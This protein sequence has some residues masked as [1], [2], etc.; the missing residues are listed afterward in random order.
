MFPEIGQAA[1][2]TPLLD[3]ESTASAT[4]FPDRTYFLMSDPDSTSPTLPADRFGKVLQWQEAQSHEGTHLELVTP[5]DAA[6]IYECRTNPALNLYLSPAPASVSDQKDW[7]LQ[8]QQREAAGLEF[9]FLIKH[10][11]QPCGTVRLYNF[12]DR[13]S[14]TWG[15]WI[16]IPGA[17][18]RTAHRSAG[19]VYQIGF[20]LLG[21]EQAEFSVDNRNARVIAFHR[22]M[23]SVPTADL[24]GETHFIHPRP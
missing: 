15:S 23:G 11:E 12:K 22:R 18:L 9:Y 10:Q 1:P 24:G 16:V 8:Y 4:A 17:P 7:I 2:L 13:K 19:L 14:F 3:P 5:D 21:F 20:E 6:F